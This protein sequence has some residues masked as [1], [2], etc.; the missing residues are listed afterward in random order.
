M[1]PLATLVFR[2][3]WTITSKGKNFLACFHFHLICVAKRTSRE[4]DNQQR[5]GRRQKRGGGRHVYRNDVTD[6]LPR[7][8]EIWSGP[9]ATTNGALLL[10]LTP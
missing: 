4:D 8:Y 6:F 9:H 5:G 1:G 2:Q 3:T 10:P 7:W